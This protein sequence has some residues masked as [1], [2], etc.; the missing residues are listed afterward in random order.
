MSKSNS[1]LS[2]SIILFIGFLFICPYL[3]NAYKLFN[4]DFA[5]DYTCEVIHG[6][7]VI[8]APTS[9]VTVWFGSDN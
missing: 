4:C 2:L 7:G 3:I 8:V 5:S 1:G 9:F 6:V